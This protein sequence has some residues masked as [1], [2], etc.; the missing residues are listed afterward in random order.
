MAELAAILSAWTLRILP[1]GKCS[2]RSPVVCFILTGI[3]MHA[4]TIWAL[5]ASA[6]VDRSRISLYDTLRLNVIVKDSEADVDVSVIKDFKIISRGT[7]SQVRVV[8]GHYSKETTYQFVLLPLKEG[9]LTIPPLNVTHDNASVYTRPI[10]IQVSQD[11]GISSSERDLSVESVVSKTNP[12]A[13]EQIIYT[14]RLYQSVNIDGARL[15]QPDFEGFSVKEFQD[16]TSNEKIMNGRRVAVTEKSYLLTPLKAGVIEIGPAVLSCEV[17]I[18]SSRRARS[19]FDSLLDDP[20]FNTGRRQQKVLRSRPLQIEVQPLPPHSG[21]TAFSGLIGKATFNAEIEDKALTVGDST[22]LFL[23]IEGRGNIMDID[24]PAVAI[25]DG[26]KVYRDSPETDMHLSTNGYTGKKMFRIALVAVKDGHFTIPSTG[27]TYFDTDKGDYKTIESPSLSLQIRPSGQTPELQVYS[28]TPQA[29]QPAFTQKDVTFTG[30]DLLPLKEDPAALVSCRG[31]PFIHFA[32]AVIVPILIYLAALIRI[33]WTRTSIN[34]ARQ[35]MM[36]AKKALKAAENTNI[37][38]GAFLSLL[39]KALLTGICGADGR[40]G[41]TGGGSLTHAEAE[42]ML[43]NG[44]MTEEDIQ[45]TLTLFKQ[46]ES[47]RYSGVPVDAKT[48]QMLLIDTGQIVRR[49]LI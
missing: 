31:L 49:L 28:G 34:P 33:R 38:Q 39:Y 8:N 41:K 10:R 16:Q 1:C 11:S 27:F 43:R 42:Q 25:P 9:T 5:D 23:T 7:S 24:E 26:F 44:K 17:L 6:V 35:Q 36:K 13:G 30:Q 19:R 46:I 2:V 40:S 12:F 22:T 3:M 15:R 14:F 48:R 45:K 21:D 47:T 29:D 18:S 32:A 37:E 4:G 20:F